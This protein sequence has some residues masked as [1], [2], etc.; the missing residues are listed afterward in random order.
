LIAIRALRL[1]RRKGV[2]DKRKKD[3][4]CSFCEKI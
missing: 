3:E 1:A 2:N 4:L